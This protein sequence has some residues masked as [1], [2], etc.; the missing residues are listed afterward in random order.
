M[1]ATLGQLVDRLDNAAL[2]SEGRDPV[3]DGAVEIVDVTHDSRQVESGWMFCCVPGATV[4]GHDYGQTAAEAGAS[5][6][7]VE[8]PLAVDVPQVLVEDVRVAMGPAAA[9]VHGD[10][11]QQLLLV[12]VTGTNG[13]SSIVQLLSD[14][15]SQVGIRNEIVGTLVGARTTPEGTDLQRLF[16]AAVDRGI[17][18]MAIEVS[19]HALSLHRVGGSRFDAAVFTNLGQDHLD[20]HETMENYF[21]AKAQLFESDYSAKAVINIDDPYGRRLMESTKIPAVSYRLTDA[22]GLRYERAISRFGWRGHEIVLQLAGQHNVLNALASATAAELLG[23]EP[24]DIADALC[25]TSPVRGRFE[26]VDAGQP[27]QIAVDYAHTPDALAAALVASRQVAGEGKVIVVFGC[28]GDRDVQK[29]AEMGRVA[30]QGADVVVVTSDNPR[31]E[32]PADIIKN[33][34][35]GIDRTASEVADRVIVE[36]DRQRAIEL[37]VETATDGD[38]VLVAGK[39]HETYQIIGN[40]TIDFDDRQVLLSALGVGA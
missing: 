25:A 33:I 14:I 5:A 35:E 22:E 34:L 38:M 20:F 11:S 15:W 3:R 4:D 32:N 23:M 39:G 8:R 29:R 17:E 10:P 13:K 24:V 1:T 28:G 16:R 21:E 7:L 31:S 36:S 2:V 9:A 30:Q 19:S 18:A 40:E 27:F 37:A 12:G 6:L 26:A